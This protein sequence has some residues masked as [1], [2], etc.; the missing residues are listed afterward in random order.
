MA[1]RWLGVPLTSDEWYLLFG[2]ILAWLLRALRPRIERLPLAAY[3]ALA[4]L[5]AVAVIVLG[6]LGFLPF[7]GLGAVGLPDGVLVAAH[8]AVAVAVAVLARSTATT[9]VAGGSSPFPRSS[10]RG[11]W[12]SSCSASRGEVAGGAGK[13]AVL[14]TASLATMVLFGRPVFLARPAAGGL[15]PAGGMSGPSGP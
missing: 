11:T 4:P 2:A 12:A 1:Q 6:V 13:L 3:V 14:V 7:H 10:W 9:R 15:A 8:A 5:V